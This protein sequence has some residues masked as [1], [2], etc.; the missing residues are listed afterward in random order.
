[1]KLDSQGYANVHELIENLNKRDRVIDFAQL[2]EIVESCPKQRFR[3]NE[4]KTLIRASQGH[5]LDIDLG[6]KETIPPSVLYHGTATKYLESI[7]QTGL[8]KRQRHHVHLTE[9]I[10]TAIVVGARRGSVVILEIDAAKMHQEGHKFYV[11]DNS[12]W[13][14]DSVD[15]RYIKEM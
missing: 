6:Y 9:T 13:L 15:I 2:Q 7:R 10:A 5:S 11:S 14:T 1:M 4:D 12:V 3:F 8:N